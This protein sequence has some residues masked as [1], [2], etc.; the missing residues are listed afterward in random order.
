MFVLHGSDLLMLNPHFFFFLR[1]RI[2]T[3]F[4]GPPY[5]G[6]HEN[7]RDTECIPR[8]Q[9]SSVCSYK[10]GSASN[11][12]PLSRWER[13]THP[14]H[15]NVTLYLTDS[16]SPPL[17]VFCLDAWVNVSLPKNS[18]SPSLSVCSDISVST[19]HRHLVVH[20]SKKLRIHTEGINTR[21]DLY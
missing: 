15:T 16:P 13:A 7:P 11:S 12:P 3:C 10:Q 20:R 18:V 2:R 1:V 8:P 6:A 17:S 9:T 21:K 19:R 5:S 4:F 14:Q